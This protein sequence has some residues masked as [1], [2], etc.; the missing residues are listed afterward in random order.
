MPVFLC[1]WPNGD[2]SI[3]YAAD[4][5]DAAILLDEFGNPDE[6][7][8]HHL[9]NLLVDFRLED[10]GTLQAAQ[11]GE[12]TQQEILEN[13]FPHLDAALSE[14]VHPDSDPPWDPERVRAAVELERKRGQKK[15]RRGKAR[16]ARTE[17]GRE[18]QKSLGAPAALIDRLTE[19]VGE[20]IL[21]RAKP[22]GPKH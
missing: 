9:E 17:L 22:K 1:R 2:A 13:A 11:W 7:E 3:V 4:A 21:E 19:Q 6:A 16:E 18:L 5:D 20:K 15:R 12:A 14:F 8:L 10:D